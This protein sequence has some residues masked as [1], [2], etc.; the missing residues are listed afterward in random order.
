MSEDLSHPDLRFTNIM[1]KAIHECGFKPERFPYGGGDVV[2]VVVEKL[3]DMWSL[4]YRLGLLAD[5]DVGVI[6]S[7]TRMDEELRVIYFPL[8]RYD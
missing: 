2:C 1:E 7:D 8:A 4:F 6:V 3:E 5:E